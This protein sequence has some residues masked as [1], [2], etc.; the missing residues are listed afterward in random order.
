MKLNLI[1]I[2]TEL[3]EAWRI[4]FSPWPEVKIINGNILK[5]AHNTIVSP[6]NSYGFMDG[7]I[8]RLYT[9]FFGL[10]PQ[11]A[12]QQKI[13]ERPEGML[14]VGAAVLVRTGH[15]NIPYM[16]AAP[17]MVSPEPVPARNCYSAMAAILRIAD[18]YRDIVT[19]IFCPGLATGIGM[20]P[21]K[22]AAREMAEAYRNWR[23]RDSHP[24]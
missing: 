12:I 23:N 1:D 6:A 20:V 5:Y 19:D 22:T 8:D 11:E 15:R 2:N 10:A 14:P 7:G 18:V 16:I 21:P 24:N 9:E 4:E 17:T 3:T 13:S